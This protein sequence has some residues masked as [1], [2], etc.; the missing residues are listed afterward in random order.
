MNINSVIVAFILLLAYLILFAKC[1]VEIPPPVQCENKLKLN[2]LWNLRNNN[3]CLNIII[4]SISIPK[5]FFDLIFNSKF[6]IKIHNLEFLASRNVLSF[7]RTNCDNFMVFLNSSRDIFQLFATTNGSVQRFLPFSQLYVVNPDFDIS[8]DENSLQYIYENG[9]YVYMVKTTIVPSLSSN[10]LTITALRNVL[11]EEI[12]NVTSS[13]RQD[14][15][16]YF[17]SYKNHPF[18]NSHYKAK[19]F[20][21]SLF[22]C[23]PYVI[24][25]SDDKFDGLEYRIV[26]ETVKNWTVEHV[27]CDFSNKIL[28]PWSTVLRN[29]QKNIT[30]LAMC[31]V[32]LNVKSTTNFDASNYVDFQCGT[33]LGM[34][35]YQSPVSPPELQNLIFFCS[36]PKPKLLNAASFLYLSIGAD[37]WCATVVSLIVMSLCFTILAKVGQKWMNNS[38]KDLVYVDFTRSILD[39]I[40]VAT[41]HGLEK[42]PKQHSMRILLNGLGL[43]TIVWV[44]LI[45][46]TENLYFQMDTRKFFSRCWIQY[47]LYFAFDETDALE[48]N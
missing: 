19:V 38:W 39:A 47:G 17:G 34:L 32:W 46:C 33:F 13:D 2:W 4:E 14:A 3:R 12:L 28:D 37:V 18:F 36:V 25:L 23:A 7:K 9:L 22:N 16:R 44:L 48:T 21:L 24:Y 26:K 11:T 41:S 27:K 15:I 30:D 31:S 42:F 10:I 6:L 43:M 1:S 45:K 35:K 8:L 29:V 20:R 40:D 5:C